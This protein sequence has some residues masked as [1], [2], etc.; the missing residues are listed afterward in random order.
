[1]NSYILGLI[2]G[3]AVYLYVLLVLSLLKYLN[4]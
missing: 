3:M 2:A 4:S 1:M